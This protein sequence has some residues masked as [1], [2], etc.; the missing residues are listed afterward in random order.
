MAL[1][2]FDNVLLEGRWRRPLRGA[3][4][5]KNLSSVLSTLHPAASFW[6]VFIKHYAVMES[7]NTHSVVFKAAEFTSQSAIGL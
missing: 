7:A 5:I 6:T 2:Y 4:C 1:H 3:E